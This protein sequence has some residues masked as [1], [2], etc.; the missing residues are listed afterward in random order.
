MKLRL[1]FFEDQRLEQAALSSIAVEV[2][3]ELGLARRGIELTVET[4]TRIGSDSHDSSQAVD[5]MRACLTQA[6]LANADANI[7]FVDL[8]LTDHGLTPDDQLSIY[9]ATVPF[10]LALPVDA[11]LLDK[12][13]CGGYALAWKAFCSDGVKNLLV[14]ATGAHADNAVRNQLERFQGQARTE[15]YNPNLKY[16]PEGDS[17]STAS[18]QDKKRYITKAIKKWLAFFW[19]PRARI[20]PED[21]VAWFDE[22]R[23]TTIPHNFASVT[24]QTAY[25][26]VVCDYLAAVLQ[27][28]V[29]DALSGYNALSTNEKSSLH[30]Y[31]KALVGS[32]AACHCGKG[33]RLQWRHLALLAAACA[34]SPGTW[35]FT[36]GFPWNADNSIL[37]VGTGTCDK[38]LLDCLVGTQ[39]DDAKG[40][41]SVLLADKHDPNLSR[42]DTITTS[43]GLCK[44]KVTYDT[45]ELK[46]N[47]DNGVTNR[48]RPT[49][50]CS[51][52]LW[53]LNSFLLSHQ[54]SIGVN[55]DQVVSIQR[56]E[57]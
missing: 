51:G 3:N 55:N 54:R 25:R 47:F 36:D 30:E 52:A 38:P 49:N 32:A 39:S 28:S 33:W 22:K 17:I 37:P 42:L 29:V 46:R 7:L 57:L 23:G 20:H 24:D 10:A 16:Y 31:L 8:V 15:G 12:A 21:S 48:T 13:R 45:C 50:D 43:N 2:V 35:I 53:D 44:I 41:F 9:N 56:T 14:I 11:A 6:T 19:H 34:P 1:H 26:R 4:I 27:I 18:E 40:A 5:A